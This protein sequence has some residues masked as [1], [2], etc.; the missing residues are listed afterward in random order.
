MN[1]PS[2]KADSSIRSR[3]LT[4]LLIIAI[5]L[6][7]ISVLIVI[8]SYLT[9]EAPLPSPEPMLPLPNPTTP[10]ESESDLQT[11]PPATNPT[12]TGKSPV[13]PTFPPVTEPHTTE[14]P[15][16]E[17]STDSV[18][19]PPTLPHES[20]TEPLTDPVTS[21]PETNPPV[22]DSPATKPPVTTEPVTEPPVTKPPVTTPPM[23]EPPQTIPPET[24]APPITLPPVTD[25]P[26]TKPIETD[27]PN[28]TPPETPPP[29][30]SPEDT[31]PIV[32]VAPYV[33]LIDPEEFADVLLPE[34][35]KADNNYMK[36]IL[37]LG[38]SIMN[39]MRGY[40]FLPGGKNSDRLLFPSS[41]T[42]TLYQVMDVKVYDHEVGK[43]V[44]VR[45]A[46]GRRQ[47]PL[48]V[49]A[50]GVNGIGWETEKTFR[51]EYRT[52]IEGIKEI[53]PNTTIVLQSM[54]P[55]G[56]YY[57]YP[58]MLNNEKIAK[59]NLWI[60]E[61]ARE[62]GLK[63]LYNAPVMLDADGYLDEDYASSDGLHLDAQ[64]YVPFLDFFL[65]H[66]IPGF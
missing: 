43:D 7:L 48:L 30:S 54:L 53:S 29:D 66:R 36:K 63:M 46:I 37:F 59:G 62:Y 41:G 3:R 15:S 31:E 32:T 19:A 18:T 23:T 42:I 24:T 55:V 17:S 10:I 65:R 60:A 14:P 13:L 8:P 35:P 58:D 9:R 27:P 33:D 45:E 2:H 39:G 50:L 56:R 40:G 11:V 4:I 38:D 5:L 64:A 22:T 34:T 52:L 6:L 21:A 28:T 12:E 16:T 49:I 26:V 20:E 51:K 1:A 57:E 61:I 25:P 47:P 44:P